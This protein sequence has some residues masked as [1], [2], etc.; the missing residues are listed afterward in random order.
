MTGAARE[1]YSRFTRSGK[2]LFARIGNRPPLT[3]L[4]RCREA[5]EAFAALRQTG[6]TRG[7][8]A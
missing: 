8:Y 3:A 2:D 7:P 4:D 6:E 1:G 5:E